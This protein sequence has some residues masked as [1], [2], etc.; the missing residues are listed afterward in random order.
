MNM[1]SLEL[2]MSIKF[3]SGSLEQLDLLI[4]KIKTLNIE[5]EKL[6][7]NEIPENINSIT[8]NTPAF[9]GNEQEAKEL[10]KQ[11]IK[12]I[13]KPQYFTHR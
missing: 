2:G 11:I 5:L 3:N 9:I 12:F 6:N 13:N 1:K 7:S 8:I 10:A 4:S